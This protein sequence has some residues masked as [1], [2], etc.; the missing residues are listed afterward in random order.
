[1]CTPKKVIQCIM[2]TK[3][4]VLREALHLKM[5]QSGAR[6]VYNCVGS[7]GGAAG[8]AFVE[9]ATMAAVEAAR[10]AA[11][12]ASV[13]AAAGTSLEVATVAAIEGAGGTSV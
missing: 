4:S 8:G 13:E 3:N 12:G 9:A 10:E 5:S 7:R 1:M 2:N 11:A 6:V